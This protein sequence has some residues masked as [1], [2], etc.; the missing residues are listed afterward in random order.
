MSP[1]LNIAMKKKLVLLLMLFLVLIPVMAQ[2]TKDAKKATDADVF[3]PG[4]FLVWSTGAPR[5]RQEYYQSFVDSIPERA[6]N[7]TVASE[8][9]KTMADGQQRIAMYSLA[10]DKTSLPEIIQLDTVGVVELASA[11]LILDVTDYYNTVKHEFIDGAASDG[12]VNGRVYGLPDSVRP[13][14]LYYNKTIFDK[15]GV[16]PAMMDTFDGYLQAGRLLKERSNGT[17][18]L[19]YVDPGSY[20]WR[21]WGRR[22]LMPQANARIWD[23]EGNIIIGSDPGA[24]LALNFLDQLHKEGLLYKTTMFQQPLYEATDEGKI[25]TFYMGAFWDEFMRKNIRNT[26][27]EWRTLPA[28]MF[29]EVGKRGAPVTNSFC[30]VNTGTNEYEELFYMIWYDYQTNLEKR[31]AWAVEMEAI[32]GPYTNPISKELLKDPF[33]KEPSPFYGGQSFRQAEAEGL[34]NAAQNMPVTASDAEADRIISAE[35]EKYVAGEQS[36]SQAIANMDKELKI[37]IKKAKMP[38]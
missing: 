10:G 5:Y 27:G 3:P 36:M 28:P 38:K 9:L 20:T 32:N 31:N 16:D 23:E 15:Y 29:K 37:R 35:L 30:A 33:W 14:L 18:F 1:L 13:Q 12:T 19:S 7:V 6:P 34:N 22:G 11:G 2:G 24:K 4:E 8:T 21:Y 26:R 25:A 17:V